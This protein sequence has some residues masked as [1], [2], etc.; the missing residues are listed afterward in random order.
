MYSTPEIKSATSPII[1]SRGGEIDQVELLKSKYQNSSKLFDLDTD[2]KDFVS[3]PE[4]DEKGDVVIDTE[5]TNEHRPHPL[6]EKPLSDQVGIEAKDERENPES[7]E[8]DYLIEDQEETNFNYLATDLNNQFDNEEESELDPTMDLITAHRYLSGILHLN[9]LFSN[10]IAS[11]L[12]VDKV[13]DINPKIV[14]DFVM[15]ID[16]EEVFNEL[17]C[18]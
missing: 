17:Q 7:D 4:L 6:Q 2:L 5:M 1:P 3:H 15:V 8:D 11:W 9:I 10:G 16:L 14:A 13:K 12:S 18:R